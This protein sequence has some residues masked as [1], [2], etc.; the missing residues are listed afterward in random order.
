[1]KLLAIETSGPALSVAA[2][3]NNDVKAEVFF[4]AG[5]IHSEKL[6][7]SIEWLLGQL[8]WELGELERIAVSIGPGS[9]TGIRV[10][11]TCGRTLAQGLGVGMVGMTSLDILEAGV[12][13]GE[14]K[15]VPAIDA[16]R[17]EVFVKSK[18]AKEGV[19]IKTLQAFIDAIKKSKAKVLVAGSAA[20]TYRDAMAKALGRK[21]IFA[22][23]GMNLPR[24][25]V[26]AR[27]AAAGK[28]MKYASVKPLYIR[29]SWAE[30]KRA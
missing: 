30:E 4:H 13:Q 21:V 5:F 9:F 1:M 7:P 29:K 8:H 16:L 14:Y 22:E 12:P 15:V 28:E 10:G 25:G 24:A 2:A 18:K 20:I 27:C 11:M 6:I 26:L 17:G 3:E 19:E 23:Q